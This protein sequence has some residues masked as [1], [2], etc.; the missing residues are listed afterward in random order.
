MNRIDSNRELECSTCDRTRPT[1]V[2]SG[3]PRVRVSVELV[4]LYFDPDLGLDPK[5]DADADCSLD[6]DLDRALRCLRYRDDNGSAGHGSSGSTN[7]S[8]SRAS[9]VKKCDPL[10]SLSR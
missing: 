1:A 2:H 4:D 8:G 9:R 7:L 5:L 3:E 6:S 10:S